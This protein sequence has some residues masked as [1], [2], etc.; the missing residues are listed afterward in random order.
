MSDTSK[1]T[2]KDATEFEREQLRFFLARSDAAAVLAEVNPSLAWLPMLVELKLINAETQLAPWIEKNFAEAD[3]I[4]EV[5]ANIRFFG[6]DTADILEFRL[7]QREGLPSVIMMCWRL[8][9]R[10]MRTQK[11]GA[12]GAGWFDIAPRIKRGEH[13]TELIERL[14]HVLRPKVHVG[15]RFPLHDDEK[16]RQE[17]EET[18]TR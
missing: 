7:N 18:S 12:L 4:R 9:I 6:P 14:G 13:S 8:I 3:A 10:H 2:P 16:N 1:K 5:A 17:P 11:R 15:K